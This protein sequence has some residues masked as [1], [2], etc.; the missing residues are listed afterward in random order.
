MARLSAVGV[1]TTTVLST[2]LH[3]VTAT[4]PLRR[5]PSGISVSVSC[6]NIFPDCKFKRICTVILDVKGA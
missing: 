6:S 3:V 5:G 4:V 2:W 1:P